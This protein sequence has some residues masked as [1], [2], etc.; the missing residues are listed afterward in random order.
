MANK[1]I[2]HLTD[3][4]R[5]RIRENA[6]GEHVYCGTDADA[7]IVASGA[8]DQSDEWNEDARDEAIEI[9]RNAIPSGVLPLGTPPINE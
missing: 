3:D 5:A 4:E 1:D 6:S 9:A 2:R 7:W 8:C